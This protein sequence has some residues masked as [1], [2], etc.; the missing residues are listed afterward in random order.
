MKS[1]NFVLLLFA[2][3]SMAIYAI[4]GFT[5]DDIVEGNVEGDEI[6]MAFVEAKNLTSNFPFLVT[7]FLSDSESGEIT[8]FAFGTI[9]GKN[10]ILTSMKFY[11][12]DYIHLYLGYNGSTVRILDDNFELI[13]SEKYDESKGFFDALVIKLPNIDFEPHQIIQLNG[14]PEIPEDQEAFTILFQ[15][16]HFIPTTFAV[17]PSE[18][19]AE[20]F[21]KHGET[22]NGEQQSCGRGASPF[23]DSDSESDEEEG[24]EEKKKFNIFGSPWFVVENEKPAL[25][26]FNSFVYEKITPE[27]NIMQKTNFL[28]SQKF[29]NYEFSCRNFNAS[30]VEN[31]ST[32]SDESF[33]QVLA[34]NP[35]IVAISEKSKGLFNWEQDIIGFGVIHSTNGFLVSSSVASA[36]AANAEDD[37]IQ[38]FISSK[39]HKNVLLEEL[40]IEINPMKDVSFW[41]D[42]AFVLSES[43]KFD[44]DERAILNNNTI[45]HSKDL[46]IIEHTSESEIAWSKYDLYS[47]KV[48]ARAFSDIHC[49]EFGNDQQICG[50]NHSERLPSTPLFD[51]HGKLV[52]IFSTKNLFDHGQH[53]DV[54]TRIDAN[55]EWIQS[56]F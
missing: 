36:I 32:I 30:V 52:G 23:I 3:A 22:F 19:C 24:E 46:Q 14:N 40:Q 7:L 6:G 2:V 39:N 20:H 50:P 54:F 42:I 21:K 28:C 37:E 44:K 48:C 9:I 1:N 56:Y 13:F 53:V 34:E 17:T 16:G 47:E 27:I 11:F 49:C 43:L 55:L 25:I 45:F 41:H 51:D 33:E 4:D 18:M 29:V 15:Q 38:Y 5:M 12:A 35:S 31:V 10:E 8:S 26:G